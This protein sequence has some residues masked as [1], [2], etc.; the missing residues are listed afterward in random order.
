M[1]GGGAGSLSVAEVGWGCTAVGALAGGVGRGRKDWVGFTVTQ[2]AASAAA[3]A[4]RTQE[5]FTADVDSDSVGQP[6]AF[7]HLVSRFFTVSG[8][9]ATPR[10]IVFEPAEP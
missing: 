10:C 6:M 2:P 1:V 7:P 4:T 3:S 5:C 9:V 8:L